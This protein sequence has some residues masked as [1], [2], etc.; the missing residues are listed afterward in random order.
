M[1]SDNDPSLYTIRYSSKICDLLPFKHMGGECTVHA[2]L[3]TIFF[4]T[5]ILSS[6]D[7]GLFSSSSFSSFSIN[8]KT[9]Q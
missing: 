6:F 1:N 4:I 5:F 8:G 9:N 3:N 7:C 2:H